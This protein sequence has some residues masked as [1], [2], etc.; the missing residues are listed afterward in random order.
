MC[1][2]WHWCLRQNSTWRQWALI[3]RCYLVMYSVVTTL[4]INLTL[5]YIGNSDKSVGFSTDESQTR[6]RNQEIL[7]SIDS[8]A[9]QWSQPNLRY[10]MEYRGR[11]TILESILVPR[12]KRNWPERLIRRIGQWQE[13]SHRRTEVGRSCAF[14][15]HEPW[16]KLDASG[17]RQIVTGSALYRIYQNQVICHNLP[18]R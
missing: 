17:E 18:L 2:S 11:S 15:I 5:F 13:C 16:T 8:D 10:D 7:L 4:Y 1:Q 12:R 6:Y 3:F 9:L 14:A